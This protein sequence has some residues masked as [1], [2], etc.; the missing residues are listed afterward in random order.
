MRRNHV[1]HSFLD[2][3]K[4]LLYLLWNV[5]QVLKWLNLFARSTSF[6]YRTTIIF[7]LAYINHQFIEEEKATLQVS[8]LAIQRGFGIFDFFRT[9]NFVP[10]FL[11]DYLDRFFNS[12]ASLRLQPTYIRKELT[13]IIYELI[14][15]NNE[16]TSGIKMM[17]TGGYSLDGY[18]PAAASNL[19]M[20]QQK[21]PEPAVD[22]FDS[23]IKVITHEHQRELPAVKSINYLMGIWLQQKVKD[24]QAA[25]VLY[26]K[27]GIVSE[28]PR[29]N[30][31]MITHDGK[32]VTPAENILHGITRKQL[33]QLA[34]KNYTVEVRT[35]TID[36]IKT[37]AEVFMTSTTKRLLPICRIDESVIGSGKAGPI[38][39]L[40]NS[41][42]IAMEQQLLNKG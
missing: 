39:S 1:P 24:Q 13:A 20:L 16:P 4:K 17:V 32:V 21:L 36:E 41:E 15:R 3:T 31:F 18:E 7:M 26:Y 19:I 22:R 11:E 40:L 14:K 12:A 35:V 33:L 2:R 30:V 8:D 37:A 25:D 38:T 9:R 28:F 42:F 29:S 10:L 5:A 23:G 6:I 27:D 34:E